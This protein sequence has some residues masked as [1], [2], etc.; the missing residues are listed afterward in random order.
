MLRDYES[1]PT[2]KSP[3]RSRKSRQPVERNRQ[4]GFREITMDLD[5][6]RLDY[7]KDVKEYAPGTIRSALNHL[8]DPRVH[9]TSTI[10]RRWNAKFRQHLRS[11]A[12]NYA[13]RDQ[14]RGRRTHPEKLRHAH[15]RSSVKQPFALF[16]QAHRNCKEQRASLRD[17]QLEVLFTLISNTG[18]R[19]AKKPICCA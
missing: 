3:H 16:F 12:M 9:K 17:P 4:V 13:R 11:T 15:S 14:G 18:M 1:Q 7:Y 2:P 8:P 6:R 5:S 19:F 10:G